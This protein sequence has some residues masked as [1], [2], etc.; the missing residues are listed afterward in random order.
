MG[1]YWFVLCRAELLS[2]RRN[3][4][5][6]KTESYITPL[7]DSWVLK[8]ARGACKATVADDQR[9]IFWVFFI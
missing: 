1:D 6:L 5:T 4:T 8:V 7:V 9:D 2:D 3:V